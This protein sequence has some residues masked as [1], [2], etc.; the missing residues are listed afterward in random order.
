M[1]SWSLTK[2]FYKSN[3]SCLPNSDLGGWLVNRSQSFFISLD[4]SE[5]S[6]PLNQN[7]S[8]IKNLRILKRIYNLNYETIIEI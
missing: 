4:A 2:K 5:L 3:I 6:L 1:S 7:I 8:I